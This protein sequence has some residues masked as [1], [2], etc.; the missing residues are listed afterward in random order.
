MTDRVPAPWTLT[1]DGL[2][3]LYRFSRKFVLENGFVPPEL[4]DSFVGG[5]G[6]VMLVDYHT[7]DVGPYR[8]LLFI[9]GQFQLGSKRYYAITKIYVS[10]IVSVEN[11]R[12]N[13]AIP[14]EQADFDIQNNGHTF[15]VTQAGK[16]ILDSSIKS[17]RLSLPVNTAW[18]PLKLSLGQIQNGSLYITAPAAKGKIQ[19]AS[20]LDVRVNPALFPDIGQFRPLVA[21]RVRDFTMTFPIADVTPFAQPLGTPSHE[22]S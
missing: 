10:T 6:S 11:G 7:S 19:P 4:C 15:V 21:V 14:K 3:M 22:H 18:S 9:P 16:S 5:I 12:I 8:E 17:R 20:I 2:M 13:W 1:G